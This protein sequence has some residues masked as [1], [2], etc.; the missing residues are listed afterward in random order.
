MADR[1][2]LFI[3]L[4]S[5]VVLIDDQIVQYNIGTLSVCIFLSLS[6]TQFIHPLLCFSEEGSAPLYFG[7]LVL[8][9][10]SYSSQTLYSLVAFS[11]NHINLHKRKQ[12]FWLIDKG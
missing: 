4:D 12:G 6:H 7:V 9:C 2:N 11:G 5:L 1:Q 3:A 8:Q 10:V